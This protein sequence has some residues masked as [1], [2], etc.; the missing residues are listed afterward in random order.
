MADWGFST[1][2]IEFGGEPSREAKIY[3]ALKGSLVGIGV[4][5]KDDYDLTTLDGLWRASKAYGLGA[6]QSVDEAAHW[7]GFP[8]TVTDELETYE[9]ILGITAP[10]GL[11]ENER[12]ERVT[13]LW[14]AKARADYLTLG[15]QL[16]LLDS[17]FSMIAPVRANSGVV[18]PGKAFDKPDTPDAGGNYAGRRTCT[19]WPNFSDDYVVSVMLAV[20]SSSA[21]GAI[22]DLYNRAVEILD[23]SLPAWNDFQVKFAE[24]FTLDTSLLDLTG[25]GE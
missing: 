22:G 2:P 25:L 10:P 9:E 5:A 20:G 8:H 17:R 6:L 15:E 3:N 12:R 21:T 19:L 13:A 16:E 23:D 11:S 14:T 1:F 7:Q 24:G 18:V 4:A